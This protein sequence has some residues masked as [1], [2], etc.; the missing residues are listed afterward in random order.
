[1]LIK[2]PK[3]INNKVPVLTLEDAVEL[4][5]NAV[6]LYLD[7]A[8]TGYNEPTSLFA[9]LAKR[10]K[11]TGEPKDLIL[12][13]ING[14][15]DRIDS[16][17]RGYSTLAL[18]GMIKRMIGGHLGQAPKLASMAF[19][20][21]VEAY[22]LPMGV[23]SQ[24]LRCAAARQPG[25]ISSVGLHTFMDPRQHGGKLNERTTE[26]LIELINI[27]G[28]EYL[29]Y[30][31]IPLDVAFLAASTA[32][33]EGYITMED[34]ALFLDELSAAQA[35]HNNGGL[36][37]V[38]VR[39]IVKEGTLHPKLIKIPGNLVDAIVVVPE[40]PQSYSQAGKPLN[41]F[42]TGDLIAPENYIVTQIPLN[43]R[44]VIARR[45]LFES[46]PGDTGNTGV[47]IAALINPVA[48]EEGIHKSLTLT[49]EIGEIGGINGPPEGV[50]FGV[51]SNMKAIIPM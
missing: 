18:T 50:N 6:T 44:K 8:S 36:V 1:M 21:K 51:S 43:E 30:Y 26:D 22:N 2:K 47:G 41:R 12:Y 49:T 45:G 35:V 40:Q 10:F 42:I 9:A 3:K 48:Q 13:Y 27:K 7:G 31:T 19:K 37:I 39:R 24:L 29:L 38:Q 23:M 28:K 34:E 11:D 20:N 17:D 16:S 15:G 32:D 4:I 5:P 46:K 33:T 25:L 14:V